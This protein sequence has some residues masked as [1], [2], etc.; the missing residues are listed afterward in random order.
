MTPTP[1]LTEALAR[2]CRIRLTPAERE[3][4]ARDLSELEALCAPLLALHGECSDE[5]RSRP[6]DQMRE[7]VVGECLPSDAVMAL[8]PQCRDGYFVVPR[9][10]PEGGEE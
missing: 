4:Y 6:L 3:G 2:T 1:E 9:A 8:A 7:D 5:Y 10:T